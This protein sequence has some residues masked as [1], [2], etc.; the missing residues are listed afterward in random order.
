VIWTAGVVPSPAGKWLQAETDRSGR[1]RVQNDLS[2]PGHPEIFVI[3]DVASLDHNGRPLPG[4]A[5]VAIQ[6][7]QYAGKAIVRRV[8][9]SSAAAPFRYVDKGS[10]AVVGKN[11]A[12]LETG[13]VRMSGW[14]AWLCWVVVHLQ[15]LAQ[16][17]MRLSVLVQWLWTYVTGQRGARLIVNHYGAERFPLQE[18]GQALRGS[19]RQQPIPDLRPKGLDRFGCLSSRCADSDGR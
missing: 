19:A 2:I 13:R 3:G 11:F 8:T 17:S 6:Q 14:L 1:V 16:S 5:Q 4:V 12:V 10:L 9:G 7:G 15:F 18:A